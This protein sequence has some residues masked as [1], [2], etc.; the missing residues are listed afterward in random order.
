MHTHT[1][2]ELLGTYLRLKGPGSLSHGRGDLPCLQLT[3][4]MFGTKFFGG[5]I[6]GRMADDNVSQIIF[7]SSVRLTLVGFRVAGFL[8]GLAT[9]MSVVICRLALNSKHLNV[10]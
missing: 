1:N 7:L 6:E 10:I 9:I 2:L 8:D 4:G 3:L 5:E